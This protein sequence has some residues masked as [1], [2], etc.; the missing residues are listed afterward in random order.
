MQTK[1]ITGY[2]NY[3]I[4]SEGIITNIKTGRILTPVIKNGYYGVRL[5]KNGK[6]TYKSLHILVYEAYYGKRR[7][8][9]HIDHINGIRTDNRAENLREVT[10]E[11]NNQNRLHLLR[12]SSVNTAKLDERK[13]MKI[14]NRKSLGEN[15]FKLAKEYGVSKSAINRIVAGKTW[16]HLPLFS[17]DNSV[18]GN[19]K[20]TGA[21]SGKEL[22]KKYG[23][24]YFSKIAL[25]KR[26]KKRCDCCG[27]IIKD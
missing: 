9:M 7:K 15:S 14:R 21:M 23:D 19:P 24:D 13:V 10:P 20:L 2:D 27:Q 18:W 4:S 12:G 8:G 22:R 25:G 3:I 16:K 17:V 26:I 11:K 6:T 1:K 5:N